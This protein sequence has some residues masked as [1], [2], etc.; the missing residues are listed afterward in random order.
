MATVRHVLIA[1]LLTRM[2]CVKVF[3]FL[4]ERK[5]LIYGD[6]IWLM[7]RLESIKISL[8]NRKNFIVVFKLIKIKWMHFRNA[9]TLE[10][11]W[12]H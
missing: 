5:R 9:G 4:Y 12:V 2:R 11:D 7:V 6:H 10:K 1:L 3:E 8:I